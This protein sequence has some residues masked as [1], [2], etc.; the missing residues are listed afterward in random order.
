[1]V[2]SAPTISL[3]PKPQVTAELARV[4]AI[5]KTQDPPEPTP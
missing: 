3:A 1:M 4:V 5:I 2:V